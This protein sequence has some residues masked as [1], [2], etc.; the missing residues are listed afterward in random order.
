MLIAGELATLTI[1]IHT[2]SSTRA[3]VAGEGLWSKAQKNAVYY[4]IHYGHEWDDRDYKRFLIFLS[5]PEGD[6]IARLEL[7][8]KN[9]DLDIVWSGF[10]KGGNHPD[11]ID[12]MIKLFTRFRN[13][14][15]I[16]E[17]INVWAKGDSLMAELR[18]HANR[19]RAEISSENPSHAIIKNIL[20][21]IDGLNGKLTHVE[22]R[23]S[24]VLGEGSRWLE[25]IILKTLFILALTVECTGLFLIFRVSAGIS[26]GVNE[27]I[28]VSEK[29]AKSDFSERAKIFSED[30][31]GQLAISFDN[32]IDDLQ[33]KM[34]ES[35][36]AGEMLRKQKELY[37][38]L[39][40]TQSEIG[41]GVAIIEGEKFVFVNE[42]L[43]KMYGY[44]MDELESIPSFINLVVPE[45]REGIL[46]RLKR[47]VAPDKPRNGETSGMRKDGRI[48]N[49]EYSVK[50]ILT[51][52]KMQNVSIIRD[53]TEQ[54]KIFW[55]MQENARKLKDS[56]K[57]LE[58]FAYVASHDLREPLRTITSY[59]QM[60]ENRYKDK[61]D[62]EANEFIRFAVDGA[63]RMDQLIND[64]LT[65]SR[66]TRDREISD[67]DL[68]E[69]MEIVIMNL[70]DSIR[71]TNVL[72]TVDPLPK[73]RSSALQMTQLFQNLIT[74]AIKFRGSAPPRIHISAKEQEVGWLFSVKDN[75]IGIE[76]K[77]ADKI[78]V[79]F[80]RLH[81]RHEY[82]G[83]G[84]GLA[85][86]KKIV[87]QH[88]GR[89]WFES[90]RHSA[91]PEE[92]VGTEFFFT[93]KKMASR[94][95]ESPVMEKRKS[96]ISPLGSLILE[97]GNGKEG[98][99][100]E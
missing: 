20:S 51:D 27:I 78:F 70:R 55:A 49:I 22:D 1:T 92:G 5:V 2:L 26:K 32:M 91:E 79:I 93:L 30:E 98:K 88:G 11:D 17:A 29:V 23:F 43:C 46:E 6:E 36:Q 35:Q 4:L 74:N 94:I 60:L 19:L 61:L 87:E 75:G 54:K 83:T 96:E 7:E 97:S 68:S 16:D 53:I 41:E 13:I 62:A 50:T 80:Q 65:W 42:A 86:C 33:N 37:E 15:Y 66:V 44:R 48:I 9:P 8:K 45:E 100:N 31:I 12:G 63:K 67:V 76:K 69:I 28:R 40:T 14:S 25:G 82:E 72:I 84:I 47:P 24:F 21:S 64:L 34:V 95:Q 77:Y 81:L 59:V 3:F 99:N 39:V 56:N 71:E 90:G 73:V 10:I 52:G 18:D 38:T 57:E 85:I 58:Q 89:I